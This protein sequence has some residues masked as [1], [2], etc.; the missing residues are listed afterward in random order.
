MEAG[1]SMTPPENAIVH[2]Q[3]AVKQFHSCKDVKRAVNGVDMDVLNNEITVLLGHNGAGKTTLISMITGIIRPDA[4]KIWVNG[5]S[6]ARQYEQFI[7]YCPQHNVF[8]RQFNCYEHVEFFGRL[9]GISADKIQ[10]EAEK[11][12]N[13]VKLLP[14]GSQYPRELSGGMKRRL[15]LAI[16]II[17]NTKVV[18]L[19]EPTSGLDPKSRRDLWDILLQLKH[20]RAILL[21]THYMEE[22]DILGDTIAIM[23]AGTIVCR[24]TPLELKMKYTSG[25]ILKIVTD[26][27]FNE[28]ET[29]LLLNEEAPKNT[30]KSTIHPTRS[31]NIPYNL[32][33]KYSTILKR[34]E[35][36]KKSL[37]IN[38]VS[39]TNP[40]LE[41]VFLRCS[42]MPDGD[43]D[44]VDARS[45]YSVIEA[46]SKLDGMPR[47]SCNLFLYQLTGVVY[48]KLI[49][50]KR[51]WL[52]FL[53]LLL[54][55]F[56]CL[57]LA[58]F[59]ISLS[60]S[61]VE[62]SRLKFAYDQEG[63]EDRIMVVMSGINYLE[64]NR[65]KDAFRKEA[66]GIHFEFINEHH[67]LNE[68]L[69]EKQRE[70]RHFYYGKVLAGIDLNFSARNVKIYFSGNYY[71]GT[72]K[73]Y[74]LVT[75]V[76]LTVGARD[77][78]KAAKVQ[79]WVKPILK[80]TEEIGRSH[81]YIY[82]NLMPMGLFLYMLFFATDPF[83]DIST[84]FK[85]LFC[86]SAKVYWTAS[87]VF[88]LCVHAV[89]VTVLTGVS[90]YA[91]I[92]E[93]FDFDTYGEFGRRIQEV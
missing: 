29:T 81:V 27:N 80:R 16:S 90:Y 60:L 39:I 3:H 70:D 9:R 41:E 6:D 84:Q 1:L 36:N 51:E 55:A 17:G 62:Q 38:S 54:V 85:S 18:V 65:V 12:L 13:Q 8:I 72:P 53:C 73:S 14:Y 26:P 87:L 56:V 45:S 77:P 47:N 11:V 46:A 4:G 44:E 49:H 86:L 59:L 83:N 50:L 19:D 35:T 69:R 33:P 42:S 30:I 24:D 28:D 20:E 5:F 34:L 57:Y 66:P 61:G 64:E 31:F 43:C 58:Q 48:K 21:T 7:G 76:L 37:N 93:L 40:P 89:F 92:V 63:A 79:A 91:S 88:D 75:N 25:Y 52:Y 67:D 74:N 10:E 82:E 78:G 23:E 71:H 68:A 2:V 22:A 32:K 15:C